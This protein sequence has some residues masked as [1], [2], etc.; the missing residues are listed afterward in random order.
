[1]KMHSNKYPI[2]RQLFKLIDHKISIP[3]SICAVLVHV[4]SM[5][6]FPDLHSEIS[7]KYV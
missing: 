6:L 3:K 7:N 2:S 1:M 5:N 4:V